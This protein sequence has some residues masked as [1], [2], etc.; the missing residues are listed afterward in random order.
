MRELRVF[1]LAARGQ[2]MLLEKCIIFPWATL[3][4]HMPAR[5]SAI[6]KYGMR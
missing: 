5:I 6:V 1:G 2:P 4:M 3:E